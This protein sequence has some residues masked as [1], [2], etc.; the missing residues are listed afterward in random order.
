MSKIFSESSNQP[1]RSSGGV[2]KRASGRLIFNNEIKKWLDN[3]DQLFHNNYICFDN[4]CCPGCGVVLD[5]EIKSS[6]KCPECKC[7]IVLRTNKESSKKLLLTE[8]EATKFDKDDENR[9]DVLFFEKQLKALNDM[10]PKYIYYFW[11]LKK[12]K[13]DMSARDY[14]WSFEN[15][16]FNTL[17]VETVKEYQ[18]HLKLDFQ[19]RVLKCDWD[20]LTSQHVSNVYRYMIDIALYKKKYDVAEEMMLSL[21]YRSVTLAH[22]PYY[23]WEDRPMSEIQFYSDASFG[24]NYV[25]DYLRINQLNFDDLREKFF[26]RAHPFLLNVIS[27]EDAWSSLCDAYKWYTRIQK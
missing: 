11:N 21:M 1:N 2:K 27:K 26:Q 25:K 7:K 20:V 3:N 10:Y 6:K 14:A 12:E 19:D 9:K 22:L 16:L 4:N 24:M 5:C 8:A 15:W 13:P 18:K 23:H 17:D